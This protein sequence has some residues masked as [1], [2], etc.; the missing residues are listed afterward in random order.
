MICVLN[1]FVGC[2]V[3]RVGERVNDLSPGGQGEESFW[4]YRAHHCIVINTRA[5]SREMIQGWRAV[6]LR[7]D[8]FTT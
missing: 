1:A 3:K 4:L 2:R 8:Y 5:R 7:R 6:Y